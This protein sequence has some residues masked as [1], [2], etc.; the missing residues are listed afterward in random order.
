MKIDSVRIDP[1]LLAPGQQAQ[2]PAEAASS[3]K[4]GTGLVARFGDVVTLSGAEK[5]V[6]RDDKAQNTTRK[7]DVAAQTPRSDAGAKPQQSITTELTNASQA[8]ERPA[9]S[10]ADLDKLLA[11]YGSVAGDE[12]YTETYDLNA[13]GRIDF[14]DL[15]S[16]LSQIR[17]NEPADAPSFTQDDLDGLLA[18]FGASQADERFNASYDLNGDGRVDFDDLNSMLTAMKQHQTAGDPDPLQMLVDAFGKISGDAGFE[19][20]LD[21][22]NDGTINFSD[23]NRLLTS[24]NNG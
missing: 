7:I 11:A 10:R 1:T 23:L 17:E 13:D 6:A 24:L 12:R 19:G 4:K 8:E 3:T 9:F 15:N 21:L 5:A 16:L 20:A 2:Q 22:N 14:E 18:S